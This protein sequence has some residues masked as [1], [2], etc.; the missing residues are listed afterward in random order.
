[1]TY[2][3]VGKNDIMKKTCRT[4]SES[5]FSFDTDSFDSLGNFVEESVIKSLGVV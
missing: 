1:M 4:L 3:S 2:I 5:I